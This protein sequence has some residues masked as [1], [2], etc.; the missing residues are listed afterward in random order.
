MCSYH[1]GPQRQE[2]SPGKALIVMRGLTVEGRFLD[3]GTSPKACFVIL[4]I[5][6]V[7]LG[8]VYFNLVSYCYN[9]G[10]TWLKSVGSV[11]HK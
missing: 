11:L 5:L 4:D 7:F 8:F 6:S 9:L 10:E 3:S 2:L 1:A